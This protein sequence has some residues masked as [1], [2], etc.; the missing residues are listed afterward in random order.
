MGRF[1]LAGRR[2]KGVESLDFI[3]L[4]A[5]PVPKRGVN[6]SRFARIS[7]DA[8]PHRGPA[9]AVNLTC[10]PHL[11]RRGCPE[12]PPQ[13]A[14]KPGRR[15]PDSQR[16][17]EPLPSNHPPP[18]LVASSPFSPKFK[19]QRNLV[20][21]VL[22]DDISQP[23]QRRV[24]EQN[25]DVAARPTAPFTP[26]DSIHDQA[27]LRILQRGNLRPMPTPCVNRVGA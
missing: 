13:N 21:I 22:H 14:G 24:A 18:R 11:S 8:R 4:L 15:S 12:L 5:A 27:P 1:G 25:N 16:N 10:P 9:E 2:R 19:P 17:R 6:L 20:N 3:V 23:Y 7:P 26:V